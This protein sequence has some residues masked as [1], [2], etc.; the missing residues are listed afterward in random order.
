MKRQDLRE[1]KTPWGTLRDVRRC[2]KDAEIF[3]PQKAEYRA[4]GV[5]GFL[6]ILKI[7]GG[8]EER[9]RAR[10]WESEKTFPCQA[11]RKTFKNQQ[12]EWGAQK[13]KP[14]TGGEKGKVPRSKKI[15]KKKKKKKG[16]G[17]KKK[18]KHPTLSLIG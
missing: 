10:T 2:N 4:I 9:G 3:S 13:K 5:N 8:N 16:G 7:V 12:R 1:A 18:K 17:L 14:S 11:S 6:A 15:K